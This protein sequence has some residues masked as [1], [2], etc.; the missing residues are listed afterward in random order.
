MHMQKKLSQSF[1]SDNVGCSPSCETGNANE[2]MIMSV[3]F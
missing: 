1:V 2:G 3:Y